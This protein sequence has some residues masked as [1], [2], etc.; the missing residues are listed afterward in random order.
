[1][2]GLFGTGGQA[3]QPRRLQAIE[4]QRSSYGEVIPLVYGR[5]RVAPTLIW[6]DDFEAIRHDEDVGGK[7]G[8]GQTTSY[9]YR[10]AV[11][12]A[13]CEG[14]ITSIDAAWSDRTYTQ[15]ANLGLTLFTGA[16][17]QA[18][19]GHLTTDHPSQAIPYDHT[20]YVAGASFNLGGSAAMPNLNFLVRSAINFSGS[21]YDALPSAILT[22]YLTHAEHGAQFAYLGS[23]TTWATYCQAMG[24]FLS[25]AETTQRPAAEFLR[26]LLTLTNSDCVFTAGTLKVLPY[27]DTAVT[28]NGTT[29]TPNLT[30]EYAFTDDDYVASGGEEP[31]QL[32]RKPQSERYNRVRVEYLDSGQSY[33]TAIAE[34]WD[35]A[36]IAL[37]GERPMPA[38]KAHAI[39][40]GATAR[41]VAQLLLQRQLYIV[42]RYRFRVR[43]DYSLLDP[44]DLVDITD[45]TLG[46]TNQ[47][48]RIHEITDEDDETLTLEVEEM[49]IGVHDAP[50]YDWSLAAGYSANFGISPGSVNAPVIFAAPPYLVGPA[51]GAEIWIAV[52]GSDPNWGGC[53]VWG[54]FDDDDYR[55]LGVVTA[56]A[57]YGVTGNTLASVADPDTSSTLRV[58]LNDTRAT[59]L[60]TTTT[61]ADQLRNLAYVG[62]EIVSF[63]DAVL[64]SAGQYDIDYLRRGVY[65]TDV[66]SHSSGAAFVALGSGM[67]MLPFDP[68]QVGQTLYFKFTSFNI[69]GGAEQ[70]LSAATAYSFTIPAGFAAYIGDAVPMK[71]SGT[72]VASGYSIVKPTGADSFDSAARSV[73]AFAD[74]C[75]LSFRVSKSGTLARVG[76]SSDSAD[77]TSFQP[78]YRFSFV[79][80]DLWNISH[81]GANLVSSQPWDPD[82]VYSVVWDGKVVRYLV[83]GAVR[84][85]AP[86]TAPSLY[87]CIA[88]RTVGAIVDSIRFSA[89]AS[90]RDVGGNLLS[91]ASWLV[92]GSG[93]QGNY[94]DAAQS[95]NPGS[96]VVLGGGSEPLGP[97]GQTEVLW[98]TVG[99]GAS[100][101]GGWDNTADLYGIDPNKTYRSCVWAR[102]NGT[103][104]PYI[105]HGCDVT[106]TKNLD[107]STNSNPYFVG[108]TPASL[109][110]VANKWYLLVGVIH[111]QGYSGSSL[112]LA[113]VYDPATGQRLT[114]G[115]EYKCASGVPIQAQRV[116]QYYTNNSGCLVWFAKPR[117]EEVNGQEPSIATLLSPRGVLAYKDTVD[118]AE[119]VAGAA[120]DVYATAVTGP[121]DVIEYLHASPRV[122]DTI[123]VA[124][125]S[126]DSVHVVSFVGSAE[127]DLGTL[128]AASTYAWVTNSPTLTVTGAGT[129]EV[130]SYLDSSVPK[131]SGTFAIERAYSVPAGTAVTY[132]FKASCPASND[133]PHTGSYANMVD[134]TCKVIVVKR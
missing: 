66:A 29:Y 8:G 75:A 91:T 67:F 92:G 50:R 110:I 26:E 79:A 78:R 107:G 82:Q 109:G 32:I 21:I 113:G 30:P 122:I 39:A 125:A 108:N 51:G 36:D 98:K 81:D 128:Q 37:N 132:S 19:W 123:S 6:Y 12:L 13:I 115:N 118:T 59:L 104:T 28:G 83:D 100:G 134:M 35:D 65:G 25:P 45:S 5:T 129:E 9:T 101:N 68:G 46:L 41:L 94:V 42:N 53:Y 86:L 31:V 77:Y 18:T 87:A 10:A 57:K 15:L 61:N 27:G 55:L 80:G 23:L 116:Y 58:V 105:Y 52:N 16:G 85:A 34:A 43:A 84:A 62:G 1:M 95:P 89:G 119:I 103:G 63:R 7:G 11:I 20:A 76:L 71:V 33:N 72:C 93:T 74:G 124:S 117:F 4:L 44:M 70:D 54:S 133:S 17:G 106:N 114:G 112:A 56:P 64:V 49:P 102:W 90:R 120:T 60:G 88:E 47:L 40:H 121:V 24:L 38:V 127:M 48:C 111:G 97:Y 126:Y 73:E 96:L 3:S 22:D 131:N 69:Y 130:V 99:T 14:Q 2:S